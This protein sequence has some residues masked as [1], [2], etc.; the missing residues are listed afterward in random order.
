MALLESGLQVF[1]ILLFFR[2]MDTFLRRLV[3]VRE[4]VIIHSTHLV[5]TVRPSLPKFTDQEVSLMFSRI[6]KGKFI[7]FGIPSHLG[8]A[9]LH[10]VTWVYERVEALPDRSVTPSRISL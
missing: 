7:V 10:G 8:L 5:N 1:P 6:F 4:G 9:L 2:R 3:L